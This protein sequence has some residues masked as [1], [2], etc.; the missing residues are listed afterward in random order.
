MQTF[1]V[2]GLKASRQRVFVQSVCCRAMHN[3]LVNRREIELKRR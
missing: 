2:T 3:L 1:P